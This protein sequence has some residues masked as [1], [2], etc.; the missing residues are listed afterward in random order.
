MKHNGKAW[1]PYVA[2]AL[3]GVA[4]TLSYLFSDKA[5]GATPAYAYLARV[6]GMLIHGRGLLA[7]DELGRYELRPSWFQLFALGIPIGALLAAILFKDFK[8]QAVPP[9][10]RQF[11]GSS[12]MKRGYY[13]FLG[14]VVSMVGVR[15]AM[16]CPSGLGLSGMA[17][18]SLGGFIGMAGFFAGGWL[19]ALLLF[20][21]GPK[22]AGGGS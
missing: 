2:G 15:L 3:T 21:S 16:G 8:W 5:F 14:G 10:W 11:F 18:L 13:A 9:L 1:S 17:Q 19:M 22:R 4:L 7:L 12:V 6:V 20:Q